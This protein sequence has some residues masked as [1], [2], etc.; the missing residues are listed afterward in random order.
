MVQTITDAETM[1]LQLTEE[2]ITD[3]MTITDTKE[4]ITIRVITKKKITVAEMEMDTETEM[5]AV[6]EDDN[7]ST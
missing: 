1:L 3:R 2:I 7:S 6:T 4:E 5:A